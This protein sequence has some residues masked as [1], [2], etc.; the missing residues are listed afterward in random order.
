[1][2]DVSGG[3]A[4]AHRQSQILRTTVDMWDFRAQ[5]LLLNH[6]RRHVPDV[7]DRMEFFSKRSFGTPERARLLELIDRENVVIIGS[8]K[9]NPACET[10]L[11]ELY[12]GC[13]KDPGNLEKGPP[14]RLADTDRLKDSVIGLADRKQLGIVDVQSG[15]LIAASE[16]RGPERVSL[17]AGL[18]LAVF[19][20]R[21]TKDKVL[22][23]IAAGISGCGTY[24]VIQ[25]LLDHPP[26]KEE[27]VSGKPW[28]RA[29]QTHYAKSSD[30]S[31]DDR[32]VLEVIPVDASA[33]TG[34]E[35]AAGLLPPSKRT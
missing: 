17:D 26:R 34:R 31:R 35:G 24:G 3:D 23:T 33:K 19:R 15:R 1:V 16:Y 10:V 7:R 11:R 12:P 20:P 21:L 29:F 4:A 27:L 9:S 8:P 13:R 14:L 5:A 32:E 22:L 30:S 25:G 18:L 2:A 6:I 28:I